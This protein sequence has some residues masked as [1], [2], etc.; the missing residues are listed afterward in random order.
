[1]ILN[2]CQPGKPAIFIVYHI[3]C[4]KS[5]HIWKVYLFFIASAVK[6]YSMNNK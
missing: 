4:K 2:L 5:P 1:M 6:L 3:L